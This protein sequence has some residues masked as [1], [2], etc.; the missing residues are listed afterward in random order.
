MAAAAILEHEH[1]D[2]TEAIQ[3]GAINDGA[4]VTLSDDEARP[5][6]DGEVR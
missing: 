3:I 2:L 4:A 5:R 1:R 6:K